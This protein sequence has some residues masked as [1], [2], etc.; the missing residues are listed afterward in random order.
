MCALKM[1]PN[2]GMGMNRRFR[3]LVGIGLALAFLSGCGKP[4]DSKDA[5]KDE[6]VL[7]VEVAT[8]ITGNASAVY[9]GTAN[10]EAQSQAVVVARTGGIVLEVP[11]EEGDRVQAGQ[12]L[13]RLD[14]ARLK[15]ERE[16]AL[17]ALHKAEHAQKRAKELFQRKLGSR[18]E[19]DNARA[20]LES[21]RVAFKLADLELGYAVVTAPISGIVSD[22]KVKPGNLLQA[23]QDVL[24]IHHVDPLLAVLHVPENQLQVLHVRQIAR[25]RVDALPGAVFSGSVLRVS[26]VIDAATGTLKVTVAVADPDAVLRPGMFGRVDIV[27]NTRQGV[28]LI[29]KAALISQDT[30]TWVFRVQDGK[31]V[32]TPVTTGMS[33][34]NQIEITAGLDVG[35]PVVIS[36][37]NS[38]KDGTA[39][40]ATNAPVADSDRVGGSKQGVANL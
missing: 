17:A 27:Y 8:V 3:K 21:Q 1:D 28:P 29:P 33:N 10:L 14:D 7:P 18:E 30:D 13:V 24:T 19:Y 22:R 26:P 36:G 39:V 35:M 16:R 31:A 23:N 15:L 12:V 6:A 25:L 40:E 11:V 9:S 32:R 5:K 4:S 20:E 38:L 37:Q 2:E 34:A